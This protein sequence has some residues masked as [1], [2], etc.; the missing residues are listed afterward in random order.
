MACVFFLALCLLFIFTF[1]ASG[2]TIKS[3][4]RAAFREPSAFMGSSGGTHASPIDSLIKHVG[5]IQHTIK[6]EETSLIASE[7]GVGT[8]HTVC[9]WK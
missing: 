5:V 3:S 9:S 6:R 8:P 1:Y 7:K 2:S 4:A